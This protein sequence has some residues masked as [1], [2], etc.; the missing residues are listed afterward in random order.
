MFESCRKSVLRKRICSIILLLMLGSSVLLAQEKKQSAGEDILKIDTDLVMVEVTATDKRGNYV[1]NLTADDFRMF[2][3]GR[4]RKIDFFNVTD[5]IT[6]SRPL[7]VVFA[8]DLSGS[9][10]PS[11][12]ETL[13]TSALKFTELMKGESV[14]AA[15][16]FNYEVKVLQE[17]TPEQKKIERAFARMENFGGSTR[18]YDAIDKAVLML[19]R[20]AHFSKSNKPLRRVVVVITD[21]F[22]SS[23]MVDSRELIRRANTAGVTV[24]S[25]TLPSYMLSA[26]RNTERVITPLD[27]TRIVAATGGRDFAADA[28]DFAPV[29]KALA[30]EIRA[31]Y[32][33]AYYPEMR[34]GKQHEVR[35]EPVN[36]ALQLRTNRTTFLAPG[37]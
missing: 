34:D 33:L 15:M 25:I 31:S 23:S 27:A 6:L 36:S 24:Y 11:E 1:R 28:R 18:I 13:R 14:F 5:E 8:L 32:G 20:R 2:I 12:I 26:S 9:L 10:K 21:G 3:D 16:A 35:I 30:E 37:K 4:E 22:D 19:S 29:F 17:F 7:A